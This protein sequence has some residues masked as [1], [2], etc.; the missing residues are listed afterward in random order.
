MYDIGIRLRRL[1][2]LTIQLIVKALFLRSAS[3]INLILV[4]VDRLNGRLLYLDP[5]TGR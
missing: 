4:T 5:A 3:S 1:F 2:L